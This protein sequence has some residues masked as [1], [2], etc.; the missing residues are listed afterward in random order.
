MHAEIVLAASKSPTKMAITVEVHSEIA[1]SHLLATETLGGTAVQPGI[2]TT[3]RLGIPMRMRNQG[4]IRA[5]RCY[6]RGSGN[7]P[8]QIPTNKVLLQFDANA[9]RPERMNLGFWNPKVHDRI[10]PP[11]AAIDANSLALPYWQQNRAK[12]LHL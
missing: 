5:R 8:T 4:V 12:L 1:V 7:P 10:T 2:P 9:E 6:K 11:S 3:Y